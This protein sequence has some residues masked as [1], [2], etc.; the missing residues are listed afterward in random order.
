MAVS[1][2]VLSQGSDA[3][4]LLVVD[5]ELAGHGLDGV[6]SGQEGES[7][8]ILSN[9]K[10]RLCNDEYNVRYIA[11]QHSIFKMSIIFELTAIAFCADAYATRGAR[12][13]RTENS[14]GI[15]NV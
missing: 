12:N 14:S 7:E 13:F 4:H 15:C 11:S 5:A 6:H 2:R 8:L 10:V 9:R 3:Q 1:Q